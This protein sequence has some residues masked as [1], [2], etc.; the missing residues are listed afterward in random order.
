MSSF[1]QSSIQQQQ[2]P[3]PQQQQ[4]SPQSVLWL[5]ADAV[6]A[7]LGADSWPIRDAACAT[8]GVLTRHYPTE[9]LRAQR[10]EGG[11]EG[12]GD[13]GGGGG[14]GEGE[15]RGGGEKGDDEEGDFLDTC[16]DAWSTGT[17]RP[18]PL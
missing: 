9:L 1:Q 14:G 11:G 10:G 18:I 15:G 8:A 16:L 4:H 3:P 7:G 12:G 2:L 13:G 17:A 6:R 5:L